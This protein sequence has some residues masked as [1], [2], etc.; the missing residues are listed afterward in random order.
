MIY[1]TIY[2]CI[3]NVKKLI[4]HNDRRCFSIE[5]CISIHNLEY[6]TGVESKTPAQHGRSALP[7]NCYTPSSISDMVLLRIHIE[8]LHIRH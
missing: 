2:T 1:Y 4:E 8:A 7:F 3:Y 6:S 5:R